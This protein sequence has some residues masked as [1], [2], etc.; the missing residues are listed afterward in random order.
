M[1]FHTVHPST[2]IPLYMCPMHVVTSHVPAE[3]RYRL[4]TI[5]NICLSEIPYSVLLHV[6]SLN[7]ELEGLPIPPELHTV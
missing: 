1:H 4:H 6:L 2:S 7:T 5:H 3:K